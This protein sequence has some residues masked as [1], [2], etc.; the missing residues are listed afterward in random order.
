MPIWVF[1][2]HFPHSPWFIRRARKYVSAI[3]TDY[4][5]VFSNA[6]NEKI[7]P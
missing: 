1:Y 7:S 5:S 4:L 6:I 3:R 2:V